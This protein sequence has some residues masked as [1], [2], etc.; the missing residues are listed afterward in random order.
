MTVRYRI[1]GTIQIDPLPRSAA[2]SVGAPSMCGNSSPPGA[3]TLEQALLALAV[4]D[5]LAEATA[6]RFRRRWP[7]LP[8]TRVEKIVLPADLV[9]LLAELQSE[10]DE[11]EIG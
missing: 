11:L 8:T 3:S 5:A 10:W 4:T 2:S 9:A 6:G 7:G 1:V